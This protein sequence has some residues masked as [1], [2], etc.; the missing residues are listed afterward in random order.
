MT[1]DLARHQRLEVILPDG[2]HL[3]LDHGDGNLHLEHNVNGRL[4]T[5]IRIPLEDHD[6][7]AGSS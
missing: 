6:R 4:D 7:P 5:L 1:I 2:S 3:F